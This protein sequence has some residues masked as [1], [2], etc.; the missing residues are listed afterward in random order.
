MEQ[1]KRGL[2]TTE[3]TQLDFEYWSS[4]EALSSQIRASIRQ[5]TFVIVPDEGFRDYPGPVFPVG[6]EELFQFLRDKTGNP[7]AV[8][9]AIEDVNYKEVALH[10]EIIRI[11][12][13]LVKQVAAPVALK[14]LVDYLKKRL[15]SRFSNAEVRACITLDQC[16]AT[17]RKALR[18]S[19]EGPAQTFESTMREA[20]SNV[21]RHEQPEHKLV[22][23]HG[24]EP[25]GDS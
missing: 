9:I 7:S 16:D 8:E 15:S 4:I 14:L 10:S 5:A 12:T 17:T 24:D 20:F 22:N 18:I 1:A 11:A 23:G 6:T 2:V 3:E 19:Y 25:R 13:I 21:S